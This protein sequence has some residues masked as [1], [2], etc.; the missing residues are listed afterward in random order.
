MDYKDL[1]VDRIHY[2]VERAQELYLDEMYVEG[3]LLMEQAYDIADAI[4]DTL[5]PVVA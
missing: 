5:Q 4:R 1:A 3:D 2:L